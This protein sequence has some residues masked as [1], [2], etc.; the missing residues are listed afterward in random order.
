[1]THIPENWIFFLFARVWFA[2]LLFFSRSSRHQVKRHTSDGGPSNLT[3]KK[4]RS[5][6]FGCDKI[7]LNDRQQTWTLSTFIFY[8]VDIKIFSQLNLL[9]FTQSKPSSFGLLDPRAD[10]TSTTNGTTTRTNCR[11]VLNSSI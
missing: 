1:M 3:Q 11:G 5:L 6:L 10:A 9:L 2:R 7:L 8:L 4:K